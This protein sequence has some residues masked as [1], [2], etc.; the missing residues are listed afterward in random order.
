M[1]NLFQTCLWWLPVHTY[2]WWNRY[3]PYLLH[4]YLCWRICYTLI[5][6]EESVTHLFMMKNLLN[7][8]LW[9]T[10]CLYDLVQFF[11]QCSTVSEPDPDWIRIKLDQ[12]I[13]IG[14]PDP[15]GSKF[16]PQKRIKCRNFTL[17]SL[18]VLCRG[19]GRHLWRVLRRKKIPFKNG[20]KSVR[21][22]ADPN[23]Y[24]TPYV[25]SYFFLFGGDFLDL[26]RSGFTDS[27]HPNKF[28]IQLRSGT[29]TK[30]HIMIKIKPF[31][32]RFFKEKTARP[33]D[34]DTTRYLP[35][36]SY[37]TFTDVLSFHYLPTLRT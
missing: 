13:R 35:Y 26:P 36:G 11:I 29:D 2:L 4:S 5:Y 27:K 23:L 21:I 18:N 28:R 32:Y 3:L 31:M 8:Y 12:R 34:Y 1:K 16:A 17:K 24:S 9:W 33:R 10:T 7:T 25:I 15:G 30:L 20:A 37:W 6:D 22:H 19:I 14:N